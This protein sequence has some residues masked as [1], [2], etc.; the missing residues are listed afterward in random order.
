MKDSCLA[1]SGRFRPQSRNRST[2]SES[3]G[4]SSASS[5]DRWLHRPPSRCAKKYRKGLGQSGMVCR[6]CDRYLLRSFTGSELERFHRRAAGCVCETILQ[7]FGI[8]RSRRTTRAQ[9]VSSQ[10]HR[11][12]SYLQLPDCRRTRLH[13]DTRIAT[14]R[15]TDTEARS[16]AS[17]SSAEAIRRGSRTAGGFP[18]LLSRPQKSC[19]Q[20]TRIFEQEM[21]V[22]P[23]SEQFAFP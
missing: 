21:I 23:P 22:S 17:R 3:P 11:P 16:L 2:T 1:D 6:H 7:H 14:N 20:G 18:D 15:R 13:T 5:L 9:R 4:G 12:R 19:D 10:I 8:A